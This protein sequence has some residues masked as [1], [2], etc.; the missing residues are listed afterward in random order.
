M[1]EGVDIAHNPAECSNMG[2]CDRDTGLCQ[3]QTGFEGIACERQSCPNQCLMVGECQ[4]LHYFALTKDKGTG[5]VYKYDTI[6]D[7]Y[8]IYGCNCDS[9]YHG[10]GNS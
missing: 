8:K 5:I 6:W 2:I 10:T 9:N 1:S 4:S 3:C 7:A